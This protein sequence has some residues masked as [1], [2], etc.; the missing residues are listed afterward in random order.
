[1]REKRTSLV[2]QMVKILPAVLETW[3]QPLGWEDSLRRERLPTP[4]FSPGEFHGQKSLSGCSP[5][6][7]KELDTPGQLTLTH[8][9]STLKP[10]IWKTKFMA[11]GPITS[12]QIDGETMETVTDFVFLESRITADRDCSHEITRGLLLGRKAMTKLDSILK[13]R[14]ITLPTKVPVL[15]AVVFPVVRYECDRWTIRKAEHQRTDA[16]ELWCWRRLL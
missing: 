11:S 7:H 10:S 5:W 1:M 13:S 15:K 14:H 4:V 2:A 8:T 12:W 16:F 6:G 9:S 3:V